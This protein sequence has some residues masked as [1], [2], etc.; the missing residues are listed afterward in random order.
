[1]EQV[2]RE[3]PEAYVRGEHRESWKVQ[4]GQL[5]QDVKV[6]LDHERELFRT[7]VREKVADLKAG[8][9][10]MSVA[11]AFL[12]VGFLAL[13]ATAILYLG[14]QIGY[15]NAAAV[16]T[17]FFL[18]VGLVTF[19]VAKKKLAADRLIPTQSIDTFGEITSTFKER[20]NEYKSTHHH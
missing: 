12:V 15:A 17:G 19:M 13:V 20:I 14:A 7:E 4:M 8:V 18:I 9:V 3:I 11:I 2:N 5:Y 1:M 16:V 6:L 10:S